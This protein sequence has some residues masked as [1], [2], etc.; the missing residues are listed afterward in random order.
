MEALIYILLVGM[1]GGAVRSILHYAKQDD[2]FDVGKFIKSLITASVGGLVLAHTLN[3][4]PVGTFFAA[5]S[6]DVVL[7]DAYKTLKKD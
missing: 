3:L 1:L 6:S 7:H 2:A 5:L 4:D